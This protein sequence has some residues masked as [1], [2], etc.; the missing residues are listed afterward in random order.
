MS[1][2]DGTQGP[3]RLCHH[4]HGS[5][6]HRDSVR[7]CRAISASL[8]AVR[9][10][11]TEGRVTHVTSRRGF[12]SSRARIL[13][14]HGPRRCVDRRRRHESPALVRLCRP[15]RAQH[16]G[17]PH[18]DS[19]VLAR[20]CTT[21]PSGERHRR[22]SHFRWWPVR[23]SRSGPARS[24]LDL[25]PAPLNARRLYGCVS[26]ST[27]GTVH[28]RAQLP[29]PRARAIQREA[30]PAQRAPTERSLCCHPARPS[31]L[32]PIFTRSRRL[33]LGERRLRSALTTS[34]HTRKRVPVVHCSRAGKL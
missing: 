29:V 13:D 34:R 11:T 5:S 26:P 15:S 30:R 14:G 33:C 12:P 4:E 21:Q 32:T 28:H 9:D 8:P 2:R 23:P 19:D 16:S 6:L 17:P 20:A 10:D 7:L 18:P 22:R 25:A 1:E 27:V 31:K 3:Q 24:S